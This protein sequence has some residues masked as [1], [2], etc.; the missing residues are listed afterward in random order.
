MKVPFIVCLSACNNGGGAS[1][2]GDSSRV[3]INPNRMKQ[4][5]NAD[6]RC[7]SY[8]LVMVEVVSCEFGRPIK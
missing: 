3:K 6:E 4:I 1:N 5:G 2:H 8:N 7:Q